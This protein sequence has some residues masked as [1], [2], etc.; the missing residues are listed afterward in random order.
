MSTHAINRSGPHKHAVRLLLYRLAVRT[1]EYTHNAYT[2]TS[3]P[4][5]HSSGPHA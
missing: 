1:W 4:H 2:H 5:M 3:L